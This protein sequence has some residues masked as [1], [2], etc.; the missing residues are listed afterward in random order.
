M[1]VQYADQWL[2]CLDELT[3]RALYQLALVIIT[4]QQP[5]FPIDAIFEIYTP[6]DYCLRPPMMLAF[7]EIFQLTI[8]YNDEDPCQPFGASTPFYGWFLQNG[9]WIESF[10]E[11]LQNAPCTQKSFA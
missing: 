3:A 9:A 5:V 8:V 6:D 10:G 2:G 4:Y 11:F 7:I 1:N